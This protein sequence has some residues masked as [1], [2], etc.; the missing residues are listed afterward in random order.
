MNFTAKNLNMLFMDSVLGETLN[1][2]QV[3]RGFAPPVCVSGFY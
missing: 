2:K 3:A 1:H